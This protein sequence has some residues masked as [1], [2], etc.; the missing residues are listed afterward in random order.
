M[1]KNARSNWAEIKLRYP[2]AS[3]GPSMTKK[4]FFRFYTYPKSEQKGRR[5]KNILKRINFC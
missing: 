5:E 2:I 1:E 4:T 3:V